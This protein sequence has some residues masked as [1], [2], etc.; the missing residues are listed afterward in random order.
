MTK[1]KEVWTKSSLFLL[2]KMR[3]ATS[4]SKVSH[5]LGL[6]EWAHFHQKCHILYMN[7]AFSAQEVY[8]AG[9]KAKSPN[10]HG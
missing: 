6:P 1:T 2:M 8:T 7:L 10:L 9:Q 4:V 3:L 5:P